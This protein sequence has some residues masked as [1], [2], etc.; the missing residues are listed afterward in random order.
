MKQA[1]NCK[2][3]EVGKSGQGDAADKKVWIGGMPKDSTSKDLNKALLEHMKQAGNCKFV[4]VGK[5]GQGGAAYATS[6]EAQAAIGMLNGSVFQGTA[7]EVDVWTKK[8]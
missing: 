3:V 5:S 6:E 2:F 7:I 4:E 8:E 1:G